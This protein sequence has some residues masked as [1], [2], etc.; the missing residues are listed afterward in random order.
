MNTEVSEYMTKIGRK[1]GKAGTGESKAR[2]SDQARAAA[3]ARWGNHKAKIRHSTTTTRRGKRKTIIKRNTTLATKFRTLLYKTI[4]RERTTEL[5]TPFGCTQNDLIW[6]IERQ[7]QTDQGGVSMT[8]RNH[9]WWEL[10]H[11][12]PIRLFGKDDIEQMLEANHW[13]NLMPLWAEDNTIKGGIDPCY[14]REP[15]AERQLWTP[16]KTTIGTDGLPHIP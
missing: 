4:K 14:E 2:A 11:I 3:Y 6:H 15:F 9:G 7:F 5:V 13:T 10:N 12:R 16:Q 1:G 8:W